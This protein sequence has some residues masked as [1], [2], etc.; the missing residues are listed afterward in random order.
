VARPRARTSAAA[1][2]GQE[3]P[4]SA[5]STSTRV[6]IDGT[7]Y[8]GG[9]VS[10][11]QA[12]PFRPVLSTCSLSPPSAQIVWFACAAK[13]E[14]P[15]PLASFHVTTELCAMS[16]TE[17]KLRMCMWCTGSVALSIF[18]W[19]IYP[20]ANTWRHTSDVTRKNLGAI[21]PIGFLDASVVVMCGRL[22]SVYSSMWIV[23]TRAYFSSFRKVHRSIT[24]HHRYKKSSKKQYKLQIDF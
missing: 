2:M 20:L 1:P 6:L 23:V 11:S 18:W 9:S 17:I 7:R 4:G 10:E 14:P 22:G 8:P 3:V 15:A 16:S 21:Y 19:F 5:T 13:T 12:T 24:K